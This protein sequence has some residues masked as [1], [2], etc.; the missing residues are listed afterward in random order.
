MAAAA[1]MQDLSQLGV[2]N[3][4]PFC[5]HKALFQLVEDQ[6][7]TSTL[8]LLLLLLSQRLS[9][10]NQLKW[11]RGLV[12]SVEVLTHRSAKFNFAV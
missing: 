5:L 6:V 1:G 12:C 8:L 4:S 10:F 9:C 7:K 3:V 2:A 11:R